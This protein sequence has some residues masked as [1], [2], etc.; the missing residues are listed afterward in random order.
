MAQPF[1]LPR[2]TRESAE[3]VT[4][5]SALYGPF[6][7]RIFDPEDVSVWLRPAIGEPWA[8]APFV[9][10]EK[11]SGLAFDDFRLCF[12]PPPV[13]GLRL[14]VQGRRLHERLIEVTRGGALSSERLEAELSRQGVILQE[15]R[16]DAD[17]LE[18]RAWAI[19]RTDDPTG[20]GLPS[21]H[22]R[23]TGG[24]LGFTPGD[25]RPSVRP[26]WLVT[27]LT[28][29]DC[30]PLGEPETPLYFLGD[31]LLA[32]IADHL[33]DD[34]P[35]NLPA[36]PAGVAA[37]LQSRRI[38]V[39]DSKTTAS[40]QDLA[41]RVCSLA[42]FTG[43]GADASG[44][45]VS[46]G[47]L[48]VWLQQAIAAATIA[49]LPA[50][51]WALDGALPVLDGIDVRGVGNG[52]WRASPSNVTPAHYSAA[53]VSEILLVGTGPRIHTQDFITASLQCG[54]SRSNP[55]PHY[56]NAFDQSFTLL[57]LTNRDASGATAAT[58]RP[59]SAGL[60]IGDTARTVRPVRLRDLRLAVSCPDPDTDGAVG[61]GG[62]GLT[63]QVVPFADWDFG[64]WARDMT[65]FQAENVNVVGYYRHRGVLIQPMI[66]GNETYGQ[67]EM[68]CWTGGYIQ[69]GLA[70]RAGDTW[71]ILDKT[72]HTLTIRWSDGHT[73][74]PAGT[75][76]TSDAGDLTYTSLEYLTGSVPKLRFWGIPDTSAVVTGRTSIAMTSSTGVNHSRFRDLYIADQG[77]S[78]R[79]EPPNPV[80][81]AQISR[82]RAA[83]ELS[84]DP[85]RAIKF[86]N[87]V[88]VVSGPVAYHIGQTK[89]VELWS[90]PVEPK[91]WR[92]T[93]N[94]A[95]QAAGALVIAGP[96]AALIDEVGADNLP[97]LE[98]YGTNF[99]GSCNRMPLV[100]PSETGRLG[101]MT[102]VF[103]VQSYFDSRLMF[104]ASL[105][106]MPGTGNTDTR[107][108][109]LNGGAVGLYRR[110]ADGTAHA[111]ISGT[112]DGTLTIGDT[113]GP[114]IT[115]GT[116]SPEGVVTAA[117]GSEYLRADG[118]PWKYRKTSGTGN[119]GWEALS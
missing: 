13:P 56:D 50:G 107:I 106:A 114:T 76:R 2:E 104:N 37:A 78:A 67:G 80:F 18:S 22:E 41:R 27:I 73:F 14:L 59:F 117:P 42:D 23:A 111:I 84:G 10:V 45:N 81:G 82:Y 5:G 61:T 64:I 91:N 57:D 3:L 86:E 70:I 58:L 65:M 69:S 93:P 12:S 62:Y 54:Y 16:R 116:G 51:R 119:T 1:P 112:A 77:H 88:P 53:G 52:W 105:S 9:T 103:N 47:A 63:D 11:V 31:P 33:G 68:V 8:P 110:A 60:V 94:G 87:C 101:D 28:G 21:L 109:G 100:N 55:E 74:P 26:Y 38:H 98:S 108:Q 99:T 89:T 17:S 102:D 43:Y 92:L 115:P 24:V 75:L 90:T 35:A 71:P 36:T 46:T 34:P 95:F 66:P 7:F 40:M 49:A 48:D 72:T 29:E 44:E 20:Q 30:M 25:G 83:I 39:W 79:V 97:S 118:P 6:A 113:A 15:L 4:D 96:R 85:T 19:P 32:G